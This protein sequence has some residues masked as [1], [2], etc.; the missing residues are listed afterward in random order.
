M[1][2]ATRPGASLSFT[3]EFQNRYSLPAGC[4]AA[5]AR[6]F[7]EQEVGGSIPPT[8]TSISGEFPLCHH[9]Q[10]VRGCG[11]VTIGSHE[12]GGA[13][14]HWPATALPMMSFR[15]VCQRLPVTPWRPASSS[16]SREFAPAFVG[17]FCELSA[18][19]GAAS[20]RFWPNARSP[21]PDLHLKHGGLL[22]L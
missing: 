1:E 5:V 2:C 3:R 17:G 9:I 4:S 10:S 20:G 18:T 19:P 13:A 7:W 14:V 6:L 8:P 16:S 22:P 12:V 21:L 11:Q 15:P